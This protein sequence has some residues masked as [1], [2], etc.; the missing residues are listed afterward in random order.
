MTAAVTAATSAATSGK[1]QTPGLRSKL[2][3]PETWTDPLPPRAV[4]AR[5]L[6]R[7]EASL[8]ELTAYYGPAYAEKLYG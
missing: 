3:R 5:T 1:S 7:P 2:W 6:E 8:E 4:I